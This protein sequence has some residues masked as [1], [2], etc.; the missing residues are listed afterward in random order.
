MVKKP[1]ILIIMDG[2]GIREGAEYN[3]IAAAETP[4]V[5][6]M[7]AKYPF[8]TLGASGSSVGLPD[9]QMG[10]SE[11]GHLNLGAGRIVY[12]D[13]TRVNKAIEDGSFYKN[14]AVLDLI[15]K[16]K[17]SGGALHIMGLLSD[18]GVHSHIEHIF[19]AVRAAKEGG[20][21]EVYFH[22]FLD[23][24]DTPPTSGAGYMSRLVNFF[25]AEKIGAIA[26][27]GGRYW[28]MD[29]DNRWDRV[30]KGYDAIVLG[31]GRLGEDPVGAIESAYKMGETD[32]FVQPTAIVKGGRPV[33]PIKDGDGVF[34]VNFRADRAREIT[35]ALTFP[36]FNGFIREKVPTLAGFLTM[37]EYEDD[38]GLPMAFPPID[39][40]NILGEIISGMGEKQ[41]RIAETE[42]Y[43]HVTF[44][45]S[46]GV[47][48]EFPGEARVLIPSP[49]EVATYDLKPEMSAREVA[50]AVI[51]RIDQK[52]FS[53]IVLNFANPDMVG[54]SGVMDAAVVAVGVVDECV[55]KVVEAARRAGY[56]ALITADHG[57]A[58]EMWDYKN[59]MPHTAH[60][61][62]RVPFIAVDDE[63]V[64]R[65]LRS[66]ILADVAPTIL[67]IMGI[68]APA[69]MTGSSLLE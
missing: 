60:T 54:H 20:L 17:R 26:S 47:E 19:A 45:F 50:S 67:A 21:K 12:Q 48:E 34:F 56:T 9:G 25:K 4:N 57:N 2:W 37:T 31:V 28:G 27:V 53:L 32:E 40:K 30:K 66:G 6:A 59:N 29:R 58:E 8:T 5:D 63:F 68:A 69:E 35:R 18:G 3:A 65:S 11:V 24:R 44:F 14:E 39:L 43:A 42:K 33:G 38:F 62:N 7:I 23:G 36:S 55:G 22:A 52:K 61:T 16:V 15:D 49:K 13:Y 10:N 1:V 46:G 51:D 41:L 64:G